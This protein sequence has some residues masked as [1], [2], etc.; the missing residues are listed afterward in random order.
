MITQDSSPS[1]AGG[2]LASEASQGGGPCVLFQRSGGAFGF[3]LMLRFT[4]LPGFADPPAY[5]GRGA[6]QAREGALEFCL[7]EAAVRL[8]FGL[9]LRSHAP[10]PASPTPPAGA[11]GSLGGSPGFDRDGD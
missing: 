1:E 8:V 2:G 7:S 10:P 6:K 9:M 4:P 11:G 5:R 3:G